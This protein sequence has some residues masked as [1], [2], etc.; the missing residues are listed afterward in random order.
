MPLASDT[1]DMSTDTVDPGKEVANPGYLAML[2][3]RGIPARDHALLGS[4]DSTDAGDEAGAAL[5][6]AT[7][8]RGLS[9]MDVR[10]DTELNPSRFTRQGGRGRAVTLER[11]NGDEGLGRVWPLRVRKMASV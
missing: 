5:S 2:G 9:P 3:Q 4:D 7:R 6:Y 8:A 1:T 11:E 10:M